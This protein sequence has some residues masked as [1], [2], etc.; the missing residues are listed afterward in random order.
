MSVGSSRGTTLYEGTNVWPCFSTK[1]SINW[2]RTS[3]ALG[4]EFIQSVFGSL[5]RARVALFVSPAG[6]LVHLGQRYLAFPRNAGAIF[7]FRV[8]RC[9][10]AIKP[11]DLARNWSQGG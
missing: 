10:F 6:G 2:R 8:K 7:V 1:K 3:F 11:G 4:I 5:V 9:Q